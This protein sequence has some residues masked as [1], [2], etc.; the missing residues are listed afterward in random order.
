[1]TRAT[2][3]FNVII[4][5]VRRDASMASEERHQKDSIL[6]LDD[7]LKRFVLGSVTDVFSRM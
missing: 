7:L 2:M 5:N 4:V 3:D 6:Y 1:M